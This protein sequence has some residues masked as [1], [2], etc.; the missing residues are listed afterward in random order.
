MLCKC[1]MCKNNLPISAFNKDKYKLNGI[2]N[3]CKECCKERYR[4]N[5][6]K[7]LKK[8]KE[9]MFSNIEKYRAMSLSLYYKKHEKNKEH[10]RNKYK[11]NI[12]IRR[13][14]ANEYRKKRD[15]GIKYEQYRR[16]Y[17]KYKEKI[18]KRT[19]EKRREKLKTDP[20]FLIRERLRNRLS[21]ALKR[22]KIFKKTQDMLR[23]GCSLDFLKKYLESLFVE[24]MSWQNKD[25]WHIDHIKPLSKFDLT[26]EK[27]LNEACHYTN[28]QPLWAKDNL[29]KGDMSMEEYLLKKEKKQRNEN[30]F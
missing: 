20:Q 12:E 6:D 1:S 13:L 23:L 19:I 5:K 26:D 11:Q 10:R 15:K 21:L 3:W 28:L 18:L 8:A 4:K 27:Q 22:K 2:K 14:K 29:S 24:G 30:V 17:L 7:I 25:L 9:R 16:N